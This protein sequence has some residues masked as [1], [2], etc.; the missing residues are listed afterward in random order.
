M[1]RLAFIFFIVSLIA[2]LFGFTTIAV[3]AAA[4][5]KTLFFIFVIVFLIFLVLG[6][7][8]YRKVTR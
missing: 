3:G 6:M 4:I 7:T 2:A 1:L 8:L 5:A